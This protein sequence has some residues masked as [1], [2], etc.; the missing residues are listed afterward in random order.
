VYGPK[1]LEE[2]RRMLIDLKNLKARSCNLHWILVRDFN[3]ITTLV[4]K[5]GGTKRLDRDAEEFSALIDAM[6]MVDI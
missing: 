6:D 3:I 4:E 1:R 5:K 2:K